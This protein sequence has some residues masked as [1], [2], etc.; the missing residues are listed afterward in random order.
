MLLAV[1][2]GLIGFGLA[3]LIR[4]TG[5]ALGIG[6]V[7]FILELIAD[8]HPTRAGQSWALTV[9]VAALVYPG[10]VPVYVPSSEPYFD[11]EQGGL[12]YGRE[13]IVSNWHG[14]LV[15]GGVALVLLVLGGWLFKRRTSPSPPA[16]PPSDGV[17]RRSRAESFV[18]SVQRS[19]S[20][21][22]AWT[23][24]QTT[25]PAAAA[26]AA[27]TRSFF[28]VGPFGGG[29]ERCLGATRRVGL[30]GLE[31]PTSSLSGKRSNR[32]SYRPSL[33]VAAYPTRER[34]HKS[35]QP[36]PAGSGPRRG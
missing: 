13:V 2:L 20:A 34:A 26:A 9:N 35:V 4:N 30:G 24:F 23:F 14:G 27:R 22:S 32:L 6:F 7:Y 36:C 5:A 31:P 21:W 15:I 8:G 19:C 1:L 25:A 18:A 33:A 28:T 10:G 12:S 3:N 16:A 11:E 17:Q 29:S